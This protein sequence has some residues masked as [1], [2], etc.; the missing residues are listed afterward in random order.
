MERFENWVAPAKRLPGVLAQEATIL[1]ARTR[2]HVA[3][4]WILCSVLLGPPALAAGAARALVHGLWVWKSPTVLEAPRGAERLSDFCKSE[5][6]NEVY[7]SVSAR[8][9]ASEEKELA[10][11]I[12]LLHRSDIRVEALL[13]STD[14]DEPGKHRET[15]VDHVREIVRSNQKHPKER[16]DGIHLYVEP[17]QRPENKGAGNLRFL[18]G[19]ADAFRAVRAVAEPG[20]MKVNADIQTKI[21][22]GDLSERKMFLSAVPRVTL[23]MYELSSHEDR[24]SV[25]QESETVEKASQKFLA[26][27]Y[28][29]LG[30]LADK[31]GAI[32]KRH[33]GMLRL[34][35]HT[36]RWRLVALNVAQRALSLL[37]PLCSRPAGP[38]A[39]GR[40]WIELSF[41]EVHSSDRFASQRPPVSSRLPERQ[42]SALRSRRPGLPGRRSR[43][44]R[45]YVRVRGPAPGRL[46][47][48][49]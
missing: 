37:G 22:K 35:S 5:D 36:T 39:F 41:D 19:L 15:L 13:S 43:R 26:L 21:L 28:E 38:C 24:E 40:F 45:A 7:V 46:Q 2:N 42:A 31:R 33:F 27:A 47:S 4:V 20:G 44:R 14:A 17:Q 8:T 49:G 12:A 25:E 3:H 1:A 9:E 10:H 34:A 32:P 18:P 16:F 30:P 6:V 23:M 11:L 29:G 48:R